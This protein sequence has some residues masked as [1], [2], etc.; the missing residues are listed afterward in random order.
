[1]DV[2]DY[3]RAHLRSDGAKVERG[4][5]RSTMRCV[6]SVL[7]FAGTT[8]ATQ[9]A[10]TLVCDY[11]VD[12]LSSLAGV[13]TEPVKR[14]G[15]V[16]SGSFGGTEG[17]IRHLRTQPVDAIVDATHPFA[18]VMPFHVAAAAKTTSIPHCR[19]VRPA[20]VPTSEDDWIDVDDLAGA[21]EALRAHGACRVLLSIGRQGVAHFADLDDWFLIRAIERPDEAPRHHQLILSRG[22][23]DLDAERELLRRHHIDVM[24][25][26]NA[27]GDSTSA[28]L[29][30]AR[31]LGVR[32]VMVARPSQPDVT[33]VSKVA[34]AVSW[35]DEVVGLSAAS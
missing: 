23:F 9:I 6:T 11:H 18:A 31:E 19:I 26:K 10:E 5:G 22:P 30:A 7:L 20:W 12:V 3:S 8:E 34:Q 32:V 2:D 14:F 27:G 15:R 29:L 25:T 28:K 24:V 4:R 35:L 17:L 16:R 21:A 1:M 13:T 33:T